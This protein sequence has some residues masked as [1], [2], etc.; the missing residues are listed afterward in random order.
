MLRIDYNVTDKLHMFVPRHEH[1]Q[2][3]QEFHRFAR[4]ERKMEWGI[5]FFYDTPARNAVDR[6]DLCG[7]SNFGKRI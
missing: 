7:E 4:I 6:I 3:S 5:P 1:E 2:Q